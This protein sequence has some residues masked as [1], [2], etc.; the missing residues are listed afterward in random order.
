MHHQVSPLHKHWEVPEPPFLSCLPPDASQT[1]M[2]LKMIKE[3]YAD[4]TVLSDG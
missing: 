3:L 1:S 4:I 2:V